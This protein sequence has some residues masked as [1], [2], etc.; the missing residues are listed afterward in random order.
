MLEDGVFEVL[1]SIDYVEAGLSMSKKKTPR[2]LQAP[3]EI[4]FG[5]LGKASVMFWKMIR[6]SIMEADSPQ[7][8]LES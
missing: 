2:D 6:R 5:E 8:S 1:D 4:G 7:R 3:I